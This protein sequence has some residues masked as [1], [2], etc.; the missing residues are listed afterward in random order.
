LIQAFK[1]M[2][3]LKVAQMNGSLAVQVMPH[4]EMN[5]RHAYDEFKDP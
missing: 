1:E 4:V 2:M 3:F 5:C